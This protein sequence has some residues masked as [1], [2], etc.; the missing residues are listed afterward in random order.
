MKTWCES[1]VT[2]AYPFA[3]RHEKFEL[4][5]ACWPCL[6]TSFAQDGCLTQLEIP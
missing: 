4:R 6:H 2:L 3:A 5:E 1:F